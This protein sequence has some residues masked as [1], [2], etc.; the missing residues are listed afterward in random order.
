MGG[1]GATTVVKAIGNESNK[2]IV[3]AGGTGCTASASPIDWGKAFKG[4]H[5]HAIQKI[6]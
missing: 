1:V 3:H 5:T 4:G 2:V 6:T